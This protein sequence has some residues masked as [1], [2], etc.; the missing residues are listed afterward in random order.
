METDQREEEVL[1]LR[2]W[3]LTP[4]IDTGRQIWNRKIPQDRQKWTNNAQQAMIKT[5]NEIG[6]KKA[7]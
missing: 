4:D 1:I 7:L 3:Q 6:E 2:S 5:R